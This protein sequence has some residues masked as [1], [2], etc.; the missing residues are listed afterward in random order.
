MRMNQAHPV[1]VHVWDSHLKAT[2]MHWYYCSIARHCLVV[3]VVV[4]VVVVLILLLLT[5]Y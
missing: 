1:R 3:V 5:H 4:V 2:V